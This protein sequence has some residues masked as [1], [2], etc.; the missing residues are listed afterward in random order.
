M[1]TR[2][3]RKRKCYDLFGNPSG[4]HDSPKTVEQREA[5]KKVARR[6]APRT[7]TRSERVRT[8]EARKNGRTE[9]R[10]QRRDRKARKR[11][12]QPPLSPSTEGRKT[13]QKRVKLSLQTGGPSPISHPSLDSR[14]KHETPETEASFSP[15]QG[16]QAGNRVEHA[17]ESMEEA[18]AP[19]TQEAVVPDNGEEEATTSDAGKKTSKTRRSKADKSQVAVL[20]THQIRPAMAK[21]RSLCTQQELPFMSHYLDTV[22]LTVVDFCYLVTLQNHKKRTVNN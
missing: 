3:K 7:T 13:R 20:P 2:G 4:G 17:H 22:K 8:R 19:F 16:T 11:R 9:P 12:T 1:P 10:T 21:I 6:E 18:V 14:T 5:L 15:S